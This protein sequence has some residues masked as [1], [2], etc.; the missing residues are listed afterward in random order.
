MDMSDCFACPS[1]IDLDVPKVG[2]AYRVV[3]IE[4]WRML[5]AAI[6]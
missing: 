5:E 3:R 4:G 6:D 1:C 2:V